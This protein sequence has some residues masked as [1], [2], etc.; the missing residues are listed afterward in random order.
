MSPERG[1]SEP[2]LGMRTRAAA[3]FLDP[4]WC[5]TAYGAVA[6]PTAYPRREWRCFFAH[7]RNAAA[8]GFFAK[9]RTGQAARLPLSVSASFGS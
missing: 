9:G 8:L 1:V 6:G 4:G 3:S 2:D 5:C 7:D